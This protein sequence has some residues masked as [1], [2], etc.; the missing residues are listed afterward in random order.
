MIK[1]LSIWNESLRDEL[2]YTGGWGRRGAESSVAGCK[3]SAQMTGRP[4][5]AIITPVIDW[6]S[7]VLFVKSTG[8]KCVTWVGVRM[9]DRW[10]AALSCSQH[11]FFNICILQM[12]NRFWGGQGSHRTAARFR[13]CVSEIGYIQTDL[14]ERNM[15]QFIWYATDALYLNS[16][17]VQTRFC[18]TV[19]KLGFA[20]FRTALF[21]CHI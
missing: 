21:G 17:K 7:D 18:M 19:F 13:S 10:T 5:Q 2:F 6:S 4:S 8:R 20:L 1:H 15:M 9:T 16:V 11:V 12:T 3:H 14:G